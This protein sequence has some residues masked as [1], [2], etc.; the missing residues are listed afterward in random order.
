MPTPQSNLSQV[1]QVRHPQMPELTEIERLKFEN[2]NLKKFALETQLQQVM[3]ERST[4]IE[5]LERARP[6][7]HWEEGRGFVAD[8]PN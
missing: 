7:W 2:L 3:A 8:D 4:L 6:G 5:Q 1:A